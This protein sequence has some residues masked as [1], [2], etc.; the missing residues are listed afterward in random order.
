MLT[1]KPEPGI[2][3]DAGSCVFIR[4]FKAKN[5]EY[6]RYIFT[7][8]FKRIKKNNTGELFEARFF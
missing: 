1:Q 2:L 5:G 8:I 4:H 6:S 7:N 3:A